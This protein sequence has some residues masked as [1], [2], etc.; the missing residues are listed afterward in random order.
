MERVF[1]FA[2]RKYTHG[3]SAVNEIDQAAAR[4][5]LVGLHSVGI[6]SLSQSKTY[7]FLSC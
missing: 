7:S 2:S 1:P 3:D 4:K 6:R 5:S